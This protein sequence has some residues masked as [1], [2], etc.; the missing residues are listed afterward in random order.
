MFS[1][2]FEKNAGAAQWYKD[3]TSANIASQKENP[4]KHNLIGL[5][6]PALGG[7]AG[8]MVSKKKFPHAPGTLGALAGINAA[9]IPHVVRMNERIKDK[10]KGKK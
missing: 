6:L 4:T 10:R 7:V 2:E 1:Q 3:Y 9:S 8:Y 5:G